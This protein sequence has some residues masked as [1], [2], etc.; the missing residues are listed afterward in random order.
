[1][2]LAG[3]GHDTLVTG[4]PQAEMAKRVGTIRAGFAET[5]ARTR[6]FFPVCRL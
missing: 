6:W 1:M 5:E 4:L 3:T 2:Q